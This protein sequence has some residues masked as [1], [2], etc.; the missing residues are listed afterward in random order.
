MFSVFLKW[1]FLNDKK[2][3]QNIR[4][5]LMLQKINYEILKWT[6]VV[7]KNNLN[8]NVKVNEYF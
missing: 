4:Y 3:P 2:V 1:V 7:Y 8:W 5:Y 6:F